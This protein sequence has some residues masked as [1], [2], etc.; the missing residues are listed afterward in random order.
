MTMVVQELQIQT[1]RIADLKDIY[2]TNSGSLMQI[3]VKRIKISGTSIT[4]VYDYY[5]NLETNKVSIGAQNVIKI[6][7]VTGYR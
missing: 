4:S 7:K 6:I 2:I 3:A 5:A 1:G